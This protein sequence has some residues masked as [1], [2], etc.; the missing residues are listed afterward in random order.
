MSYP[1]SLHSLV[2]EDDE[3]AKEAYHGIFDS[4]AQDCPNLPFAPA[5]PSFAFSYKEA[6]ALL[7][8]SRIFHVVILDLR[9]P[10]NPRMPANEGVELGMSLLARCVE[11]DRFP[12]PALLVISAH[13][14]ST[15]QTR[16]QDTLRQGFHYGR[17][18]VKE[19]YSLLE[20]EIRQ[21]CNE[22]FRYCS[23]GVHIRDAGMEQYPSI[24]PR[25]EDLLRRS[26]FQQSG[27]IGLDLTWWS[28]KSIGKINAGSSSTANP[29]TK[30]L[31]GRYLLKDGRGASRPKF[32]KLMDGADAGFVIESARQVEQKLSHIKL[33]SYINAKSTALVVTEK[34]GANDARPESLDSVFTKCNSHE[35][36]QVASQIANQVE[37]LGDLL[38]ESKPLSV[39]LWPA[40]DKN[41]LAAQW[42]RFG[43]Q[44]QPR[45]SPDVDPI[46]LYSE[47]V[48]STERLRIHERSLV[49]GDL[50]ISNV[51][52]DLEPNGPHAYIFDAGVVKR[53]VAGRD[54]AV[55]EVSTILHQRIDASGFVQIC[56]VLYGAATRE[57]DDP[58]A[59]SPN[60]FAGNIV[61]FIQALRRVAAAWNDLDV[62]ALMVFDFALI[63]VGGLAFGS[64][65][66]KIVDPQS[67]AHFLAAVAGW[68]QRIRETGRGDVTTP[69]VPS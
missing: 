61:E 65:G 40:H 8:S 11:R 46:A 7:D 60:T 17:A 4:I 3:R 29:W 23:I 31:M 16:M 34:V 37:Q 9:L 47:L 28:A 38:P 67:A 33:S 56:T 44:M 20:T 18:F 68:Y 53:N 27:A 32:F 2:I 45:V 62:Y 69:E 48:A 35:V 14:G 19:N 59:P 15:E 55:L 54:I 6:L 25:D 50:H 52:L 26:A 5:P 36:C 21:A 13:I 57:T 22:A 30:V 24:T 1:L 63:Q 12:I 58:G 42:S 49:H 64:S 43:Y 66:N 39:L 51:A 10:E 41:L